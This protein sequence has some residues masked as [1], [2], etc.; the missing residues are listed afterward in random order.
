MGPAP[1]KQEYGKARAH[2]AWHIQ[3]S[4]SS[5]R[6]TPDGRFL[7]LEKLDFMVRFWSLKARH[8][9][10]GA[11]LSPIER[12][13]LLS[14]MRLLATD[15]RLPEPGPAP[16][17]ENG[18]P[19]QLTAPGG[20]FAGELRMVCGDGIVVACTTPLRPMTSTIVRLAD[21]VSG[22]EYEL[23]CVVHWARPGTPS[24][25]GLRVDG[26]PRRL[27]F[28]IP[29]PGMWRSPLGWTGNGVAIQS[30]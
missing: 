20:F 16:R 5:S 7:V 10:M 14:L 9:A 30:A 4:R 28:A 12:V 29:E 21:A 8:E 23:P 6:N 2:E 24:A 18:L 17:V 15:V 19:V 11:P 25:M 1:S 26:A 27:T 13:E 3:C 22:V